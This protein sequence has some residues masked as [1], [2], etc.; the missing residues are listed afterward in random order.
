MESEITVVEFNLNYCS[1]CKV[2][3]FNELCSLGCKF[4]SCTDEERKGHIL[5]KTIRREDKIVSE[6]LK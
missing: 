5:V 2:V 6:V 4:D 3:I 1:E